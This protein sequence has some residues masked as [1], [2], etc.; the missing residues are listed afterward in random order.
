MRLSVV[1]LATVV[2]AVTAEQ[3]AGTCSPLE[4]IYGA[5]DN[6]MTSTSK[7]IANSS[8]CNY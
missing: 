8:S 7:L 4:L 2:C 5:F 3:N 6:L 1:C